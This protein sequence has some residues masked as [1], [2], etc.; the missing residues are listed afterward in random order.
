MLLTYRCSLVVGRTLSVL[1]ALWGAAEARAWTLGVRFVELNNG[2]LVELPNNTINGSNGRSRVIV[3]QM[4]IFADGGDPVPATGL[5]GWSGGMLAVSGTHANSD[6]IRTPGRLAPF[7]HSAAPTANGSPITEPFTILTGIDATRA[8]ATGTKVCVSGMQALQSP[9]AVIGVDQFVSVYQFTIGPMIGG[10]SYTVTASGNAM[11][12]SWAVDPTANPSCTFIS[13]FLYVGHLP[14]A[15]VLAAFSQTLTVQV[16]P[17]CT[18]VSINA[19]PPA[20]LI[21][22]PGSVAQMTVGATGTGTLSYQ[23]QKDGAPLTD[24]PGYITGSN[25]ATLQFAALLSNHGSGFRC[26][27]TDE[28]NCTPQ[29]TALTRLFVCPAD[30]NCSGTVSVQ[31]IFTF[32]TDWFGGC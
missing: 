28:T 13:T 29:F 16:D 24:V 10:S 5:F 19:A 32:L 4:G 30:A 18:S 8:T 9:P 2:V 14:T 26:T 21:A 27:V 6:E 3:L 15:T 12:G 25:S 22:C 17:P 1:A 31:D 23:W 7:T 11:T 20:T